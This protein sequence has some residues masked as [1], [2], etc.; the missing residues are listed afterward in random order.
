MARELLGNGPVNTRDTRTQQWNEVMQPAST[1][2]LGKPTSAQVQWHHTPTVLVLTWL[3]FFFAVV[4]AES[5]L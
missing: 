2:R 4:R 5:V 1:Q 3:F